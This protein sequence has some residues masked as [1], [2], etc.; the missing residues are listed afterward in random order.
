MNQEPLFSARL[1]DEGTSLGAR[2]LS[3]TAEA[4]DKYPELG[5]DIARFARHVA[6][7]VNPRLMDADALDSGRALDGRN[8][9]DLYLAC[10]CASGQP[11]ALAR[12]ERSYLQPLRT[13]V[14]EI[15]ASE[16]RLDE[17]KQ[18]LRERLLVGDSSRPPRISDYAGRGSLAAWVQVAARRLALST[19][20][21][22][23]KEVLTSDPGWFEEELGPD[24]ELDLVRVRHAGEFRDAIRAALQESS[25]RER[26]LLRLHLVDGVSLTKLAAIYGVSQP[27]VSRWF[28][29][30]RQLLLE[31]T[32]QRL[33]SLLGVDSAELDSLVRLL[34]GQLD[35]SI[36]EVLSVAPAP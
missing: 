28:S 32:E 29:Q 1:V 36:S 34:H 33:R 10:A 7:F 8:F 6:S 26:E 23:V 31:R 21:G 5:V 18:L 17:L 35:L 16:A 13:L 30:L 2:F 27:T 22:H 12:F 4:R 19:L 24:P 20:R 9:C 11:D 25:V 15:D 3:L 14:P